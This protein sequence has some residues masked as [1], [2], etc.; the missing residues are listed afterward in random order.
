MADI[1]SI[2]WF[3]LISSTIIALFSIGF[4]G[5]MTASFFRK[6]SIGSSFMMVAFGFIALAE[7]LFSI[8]LWLRAF[9]ATSLAVTGILQS[10]FINMLCLA[11]VY[12]YYFSTR[13]ILRDNELVKSFNAINKSP[14]NLGSNER[15]QLLDYSNAFL[16]SREL[17]RGDFVFDLQNAEPEV[18]LG[19]SAA[20]ATPTR[21]NSFVFSNKVIRT[22]PQGIMVEL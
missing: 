5:T 19:F 2:E 1:N 3:Y 9:N 16:Y 13:H 17:A 7:T 8:S 21:V 20:R 14:M 12:F 6:R 4:A 22:T 15:G 11:I 18:R 10:L